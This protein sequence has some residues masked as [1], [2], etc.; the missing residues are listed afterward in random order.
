MPIAGVSRLTERMA[1]TARTIHAEDTYRLARPAHGTDT[2]CNGLD[3]TVTR[4]GKTTRLL[5]SG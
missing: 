1:D 3:E 4:S 5:I 2:I